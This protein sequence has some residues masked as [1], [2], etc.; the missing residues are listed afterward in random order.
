MKKHLKGI[1]CLLMVLSL[2]LL[3]ACGGEEDMRQPVSKDPTEATA[4]AGEEMTP[5]EEDVSLAETVIYDA[6]GVKIIATG[7]EDGWMGTEIKLLLENNTGKNLLITGDSLSVNGYMMPYSSL[8]V[9]VAAG[10]KANDS[11]TLMTSEL[12]QSGIETL[13][14]IQFFVEISD[15]ETWDTIA[16]SDLI[17][18]NT[19]AA[20]YEQP[21]DDSGEALWAENG[22][23]IVCKGLKQDVIWD[24]TLVFLM[25][26]FSGKDII[27]YA[28]NVSVNGFMVDVGLWSDLRDGTRLIDGMTL[29]DLSELG[30]E[31]IDGV[32]NIEFTLRIIDSD[33]WDE[34]VTTDVI[35]LDFQ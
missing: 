6:D 33:T 10:K 11:I 31:S 7:L 3:T 22:I 29:I 19:S 5:V 16:V 18:L 14:Q 26:N 1:F 12:E 27:I 24:G 2:L 32:E 20:G 28:E 17:T 23:R 30:L 35:S 34:I 21:V 13:A 8:Y 25:E 9:E 15:A 4:S